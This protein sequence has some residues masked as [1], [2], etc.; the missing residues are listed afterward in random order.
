MAAS[1]KAPQ[2]MKLDYSIDRKVY[3][4]FIRLC[5]Q[6]GYAPKMVVERLIQRYIETGQF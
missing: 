6:K 5:T 1:L 2:K 4:D 3:D